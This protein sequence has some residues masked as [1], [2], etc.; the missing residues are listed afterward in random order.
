MIY[1]MKSSIKRSSIN[2]QKN[3]RIFPPHHDM[4]RIDHMIYNDRSM[5]SILKIDIQSNHKFLILNILD[6]EDDFSS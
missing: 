2:Y 6:I 1:G 4:I 5:E 3:S